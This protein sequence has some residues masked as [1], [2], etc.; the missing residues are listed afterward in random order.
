MR[1]LFAAL[2]IAHGIAH[3]VG[4]V[5]P[6]R[7]VTSEELPYRTTVLGGTV[8]LGETGV[9]L[10]GVVWLVVGVAF[11]VVAGGLLL[12]VSWWYRAALGTVLV[13]LVLCIAGWPDS[14]LGIVANA[15]ILGLLIIGARWGWFA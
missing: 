14:R 10:L 2:L 5:I 7:L 8:N 13:S 11:A 4:F 3:L 9:R 1:I 15:V 6:W 12:R